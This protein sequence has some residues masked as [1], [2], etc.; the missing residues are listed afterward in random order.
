MRIFEFSYVISIK[1]KGLVKVLGER[2]REFRIRAGFSQEELANEADI[3]LSQ[4]G[5]I[6]R[7][8]INSTISSL[9]VIAQ[10]LGIDLKT[11]LDFKIKK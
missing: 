8:E 5:R 10:A 4:I 9:Y 1:N 7:G 11:L 6:E 3:P 2:I